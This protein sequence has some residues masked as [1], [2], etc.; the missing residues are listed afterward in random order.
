MKI[1]TRCLFELNMM[2]KSNGTEARVQVA[3]RAR[4]LNQ[5][6]VIFHE[7]I[8][9][10]C[11]FSIRL[12]LNLQLLLL[13]MIHKFLL[14]NLKKSKRF[15]SYSN[16]FS[17]LHIRHHTPKTFS[18]DFCFNSMHLDGSN[19]AS[20]FSFFHVSINFFINRSSNYI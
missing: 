20:M 3:I 13:F 11:I 18:Y 6:E 16:I 1:D 10:L 8:L 2:A 15:F 14:I 17:F 4:P 12:I 9:I 5:R 19:Y 7:I